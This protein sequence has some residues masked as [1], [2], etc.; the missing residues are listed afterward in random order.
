MFITNNYVISN[1][2]KIQKFG[3]ENRFKILN[4]NLNISGI[5]FIHNTSTLNSNISNNTLN[6]GSGDKSNIDLNQLLNEDLSEKISDLQLVKYEV[7]DVD[8][9]KNETVISEYKELFPWYTDDD[10]KIIDY[11][12]SITL[13]DGIKLISRFLEYRCDLD[14]NRFSDV[15]LSQLIE[16]FQK[17]NV[18]VKELFDHVDSLHKTDS[19]FLSQVY[20][21]INE[22]M[23]KLSSNSDGNTKSKEQIFGQLGEMSINDLALKIRNYHWNIDVG[24]IQLMVNALPTVVSAVGYGMILKSYM[25]HVYNR[26]YPTNYTPSE[27]RLERKSRNIHLALFSIIGP[28]I[29]LLALRHSAFH[30]KDIITVNVPLGESNPSISDPK[31]SNLMNESSSILVFL[32]NLNKKIPDWLK[33]IFKILIFIYIILKLLGFSNILYF[34]INTYYIKIYFYIS[35]SLLIIYQFIVLYL[36]HIFSKKKP[37]SQ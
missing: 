28:P 36:I 2:Y 27:I 19:T 29:I 14:Q 6:K 5:S 22:D 25:K 37:P 33:L 34:L 35:C 11:N 13:F 10:G 32:S 12:K 21:D 23:V 24:N 16:P 18:T 15:K 8:A 30:L 9:V 3:I 4:H 1:V 17:G 31:S 20:K 7:I 26:S